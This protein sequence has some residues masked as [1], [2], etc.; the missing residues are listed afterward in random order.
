MTTQKQKNY[1]TYLESHKFKVTLIDDINVHYSCPE[2]KHMTELTVTSFANKK[3]KF[4]D[5]P[6]L[7][8]TDCKIAFDKEA[9]RAELETKSNHTILAY[10]DKENVDFI[11]NNC[12]AHRTSTKKSLETS[13]YCAL[14]LNHHNRKPYDELRKL[15]VGKGMTLLT[16]KEQYIDN[17]SINVTCSCGREW[18]TSSADITRGRKCMKCKSRK[19]R[20][21][22]SVMFGNQVILSLNVSLCL[23]FFPLRSPI[24]DLGTILILS[25]VISFVK[26]ILVTQNELSFNFS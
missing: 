20:F 14:C 17:K 3:C 19:E 25:T 2:H 5:T 10:H 4:K 18:K 22:F 21:D 16:T 11:C 8:C 13:E 9:S 7:L 24:S 1:I 12:G 23:D 15:V 26:S 6:A